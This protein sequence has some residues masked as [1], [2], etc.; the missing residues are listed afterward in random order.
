VFHV[1]ALVAIGLATTLPVALWGSNNGDTVHNVWARY[2][3]AQFWSGEL[4]PRWLM[5]MNSGL[6]S[7]T[8]FF[9]APIPYFV[10]SLIYPLVPNDPFGWLPVGPLRVRSL[11]SR[12]GSPPMPG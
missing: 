2:F 3:A 4:Y 12:R 1:V 6:G 5:D 11:R 7:P 9:Y 8:F 10:T